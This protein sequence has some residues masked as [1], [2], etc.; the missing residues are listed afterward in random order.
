MCGGLGSDPEGKAP[1]LKS[2]E[3][4]MIACLAGLDRARGLLP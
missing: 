3:R 2:Y 4:N 1:E